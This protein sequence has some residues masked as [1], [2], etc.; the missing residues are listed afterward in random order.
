MQLT[1]EEKRILIIAARDTIKSLFGKVG[2]PS[3]N[4]NEYE[5]LRS[6]RGAFVT[7]HENDQLRGCIGYVISDRSLFETV[8]DAAEGAAIG[9]PRFLPVNEYE[10]ENL[11]IEISVLSE[12]VDMVD[13]DEIELGVHGLICNEEGRR[14]LLLP[15]VP[16]EHKMNKEEYLAAICQKSGLPS[17]LWKKKKL[18]L[19]LFT[20]EVF[21]E[22]EVEE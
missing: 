6:Q 8:C 4:L 21:N 15:Q 10:V 3:I 20:A 7:L 2:K 12:P 22:T 18:D 1:K 13:Y 9:D 11:E 17:D 5:N 19:Q 14:G 16:I